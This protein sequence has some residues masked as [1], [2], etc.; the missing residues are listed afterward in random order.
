MNLFELFVK[1]GADVTGANEGIDGVKQ[2]TQSLAQSIDKG[3]TT[4]AKVGTAAIGAGAAAA[5][6]LVKQAVEAFGEY[7]Q[8]VG[9]VDTL[10]GDAAGTVQK[11][12]AKAFKAAGMSANDYMSTA[13]AFSASLIQSLGGDT[14]KAAEIADLAITDMSDNVNKMGT[15]AE[16]VQNAYRGFVRQ[17]FTMLDNL[18]LGY[19]GTKEEMNRL[20]AD[21]ERL[22]G[23]KYDISSLSDIIKAIHVVQSELKITGTTAKEAST[24]IQGSVKSV[25]AAWQ[26]LIVGVSDDNQD[27]DKLMDDFVDSVETAG[28]NMIPRIEKSLDGV[29]K[30]VEK[31]SE[32]IIPLAIQV[33]TKNLPKFINAGAKIVTAIGQG[34]TQNAPELLK[35]GTDA[36]SSLI[37]TANVTAKGV[38][39]EVKKSAPEI[40]SQIKG[41]A[42]EADG[43]IVAVGGIAGAIKA[44][45]KGDYV[46]AAIGGVVAAIGLIKKA[47]DDSK[48]AIKGLS[49]EEEL[50]LQ[51]ANLAAESLDNLLNTRNENIEAISEETRETKKLWEELQTLTDEQG[52]VKDGSESRAK[53]I[54]G[55]L[56]NALG[57]E[58]SMNENIIEQYGQMREEIDKLILK[59]RA[60]RLLEAGASAYDEAK[61]SLTER[62]T[63]AGLAAEA[64]AK[65]QAEYDKVVV[66]YRKGQAAG[67]TGTI[68]NEIE[69]RRIEKALAEAQAEYDR[70]SQ[71]AADA[72]ETISSYESAMLASTE[73]NYARVAE[74]LERDSAYR[75]EHVNDITKISEKEAEQLVADWKNAE[76]AASFY[77]SQYEKGAE[78]FTA[79]AASELEEKAKKLQDLIGQYQ[80]DTLGSTA[81]IAARAALNAAG[82]YQKNTTGIITTTTSQND[83]VSPQVTE[84]ATK[85]AEKIIGGMNDVRVVLDTGALV[86]GITDEMDKSLGSKFGYQTRGVMG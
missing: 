43:T 34:I 17:N 30:L 14:A 25:K 80:S 60:E 49:D 56:N 62:S 70:L 50:Y 16:M 59:K 22:S 75:W 46:G 47:S 40:V 29:A 73:Q 2:K 11:N 52:K 27:F 51:K 67:A 86:G 81:S 64:L 54:L 20:L 15:S 58:Y 45:A 31:G 84:F 3:L 41:I 68:P 21:A 35:A 55:E 72:A 6:A 37:K 82:I 10:F 44:L 26:N 9:G 79:E 4:A 78:G 71:S 12:A 42:T 57:T 8:L 65:A 38:L 61:A 74:I 24:T 77:R 39:A 13:I 1:I 63:A 69:A 48:Q 28:D 76:R 32:K 19:G 85:V 23:V 66:P 83:T 18:A 5:G 33:V 36:L 7:E 53:Y